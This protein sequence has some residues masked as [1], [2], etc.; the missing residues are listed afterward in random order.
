MPT[1]TS[2]PQTARSRWLAGRQAFLDSPAEAAALLKQAN[3]SGDHLLVIEIAEAVLAQ[4]PADPTAIIQQMARAL[5]VLGSLDAA[6]THLEALLSENGEN[7]ETCGLLGRVE[8]D[9]AAGSTDEEIR[10]GH[11]NAALNHYRAGFDAAVAANDDGGASYCG[12]NSATVSVLLGDIA[13]ARQ[14]VE[15]TL[16]HTGEHSDYYSL[17]TRAEAQFILGHEVDARALYEEV[18]G[19]ATAGRRLADLASTRKQ[20]RELSL[21]LHGRR[22]HLDDCFPSGNIAVFSGQPELEPGAEEI[23]AMRAMIIDWLKTHQIREAFGS[24]KSAWDIILLEIAKEAGVDIHVSIGTTTKSVDPARLFGLINGAISTIEPP[25]E[26][27]GSP[28][29]IDQ[30]ITASAALRADNLGFSLEA[31]AVGADLS[32]TAVPFW[33]RKNLSV[34]ARH[35]ARVEEDVTPD[36]ESPAGVVPFP[37][38]LVSTKSKEEVLALVHFHFPMYAKLGEGGAIAF[39]KGVLGPIAER[40]IN[41]SRPPIAR[42]GFGADYLFIFDDLHAAGKGCFELLQALSEVGHTCSLPSVCLHTGPLM[43]LVNPVLNF[44]SYEGTSILHAAAISRALPAGV[45]AASEAFTAL[46]SLESIR[47]FHFEH[48]GKIPLDNSSERLYRVQ[49]V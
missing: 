5:S 4:N 26:G 45:V 24:V 3:G 18:A 6:R 39:Q 32:A 38:A 15:K 10:R 14:F 37:R 9:L 44:H 41:L 23:V 21:Q 7:A 33:Q 20:C 27:E 46:S 42:Q 2:H 16:T 34:T 31:L 22:D 11:L 47:G 43:Q 28:E 48:S 1:T 25:P 36:K 8:K 12:I 17:A 29:F 30:L 49:P 35:P 13:T 19:I 40:L